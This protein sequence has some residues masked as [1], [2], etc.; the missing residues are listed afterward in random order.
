MQKNCQG[1]RDPPRTPSGQGPGGGGQLAISGG[2][3]CE[4]DFF[5]QAGQFVTATVLAPDGKPEPL[6]R[7]FGSK[8]NDPWAA[9]VISQ[10]V[11]A[12]GFLVCFLCHFHTAEW[13]FIVFFGG[14]NVWGIIWVIFGGVIW[15]IIWGDILGGS[16]EFELS[17]DWCF[18]DYFTHLFFFSFS[19]GFL[20]PL[21]SFAW[22]CW[23]LHVF[24]LSKIKP[25][26]QAELISAHSN[27]FYCVY[28]WTFCWVRQANGFGGFQ[29]TSVSSPRCKFLVSCF[30]THAFFQVCSFLVHFRGFNCPLA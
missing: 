7:R 14:G 23:A 21:G 2:R 26:E 8:Q 12:P 30:L 15:R 16:M 13:A 3:D 5:C 28:M 1:L 29:K 11:F 19:S 9:R 22:L 4:S 10:F 17:F 6:Q 18:H 27:L 25:L 20:L 24:K